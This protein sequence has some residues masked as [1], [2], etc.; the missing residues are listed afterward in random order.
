[1][2]Q[3]L[4]IEV[5]GQSYKFKTGTDYA[6][7]REVADLV[8]QEIGKAST[9]FSDKPAALNK[10]AILILAALNIAEEYIEIKKDYSE[11]VQNISKRSNELVHLMELHFQ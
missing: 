4:T 5:L 7:A 1:L 2:E 8:V 3:L 6:A 9:L 10:K 11:L